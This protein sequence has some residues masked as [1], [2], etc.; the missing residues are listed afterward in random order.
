MFHHTPALRYSAPLLDTAL[1]EFQEHYPAFERTRVLDDLRTTDYA[2]MDKEGQ[3]YLDYTGGGLY[4]ERQ[5]RAHMNLLS[6]RVY[7]NPHSVNPTSSAMTEL[8]EHARAF[9]LEYFNADPQEYAAIFTANASGAL[10]LVGESYPFGPEGHYLLSFD[11][12]N[13]VNGIREFARSRGTAITYVP[14]QP[15]DLRMSEAQVLAQLNQPGSGPSLFA[16]PAQSNFSGAQHPLEW[17]ELA[18]ARG[19]DVLVDCAAFVP[20][21]RLDQIGR[22]HV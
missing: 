7:G 2:R 6:Q 20:T 14:M 17:I 11:N 5:L 13:S 15:P 8:V 16:Y 4:A 12:H 21:N 22:A 10:K 18:H 3:I 9:V 1:A 19:W